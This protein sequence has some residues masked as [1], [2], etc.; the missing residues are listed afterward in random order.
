MYSLGGSTT[1]T[2]STTST[3]A[4]AASTSVSATYVGCYKDNGD[5]RTLNGSK[6][7]SSSMT[8]SV[9]NS[10]CSGL[11]Y[12]YAGTEY[13]DEVS[14]DINFRLI[15]YLLRSAT[16]VTSWTLQ[17]SPIIVN[18]NSLARVTALRNAVVTLGSVCILS[19]AQQP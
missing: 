11:G 9:C 5:N 15:T 16:V 10:Y 14:I 3:S 7:I 2:S 18:V 12:T 1:T 13:Y 17:R 4:A 8:P 6:K 19:A